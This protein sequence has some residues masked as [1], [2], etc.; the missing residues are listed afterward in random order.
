MIGEWM[1]AMVRASWQGAIAVALVWI[2]CKSVPRLP[3]NIRCWLW[4][5]ALLKTLLAALPLGPF[6]VPILPRGWVEHQATIAAAGA[7][8]SSPVA[9]TG[10]E[11]G[12]T[13]GWPAGFGPDNAGRPPATAATVL[14]PTTANRVKG[15][16]APIGYTLLF[17]AWLAVLVV[18]LGTLVVRIRGAR[19]W[20]PEWQL[21]KDRGVLALGERLSQNLGLFQP[22]VLFEADSCR[23]PVVFGAVR[24]AIVLPARLVAGSTPG[25]LE[26]ILAHEM[27]HIRRYDL[28]GNW[29]STLVSGLFFFHPLVWLAVRESRLSQEV[30]CDELTVRRPNVSVADYG[31]LLVELATQR[32]RPAIPLLTV[33]V[34]ESF[35]TFLKR[36]LSAMKSI[37]TRSRKTFVLS[38]AVAVVAVLG[39]LPWRLAAA[40]KADA[41]PAAGEPG[42]QRLNVETTSGRFKI[43]VDRVRYLPGHMISM[44]PTAL[45]MLSGKM[46]QHV[47]EQSFPGGMGRAVTGTMGGGGGGV[48][49]IPNLALDVVVK[50]P[51]LA[52]KHQLVCEIQ[53]KVHAVDDRGHD[54]DS[55]DNPSWLKLQL[56]GVDYPQGSGRVA[57]HLNLP[58]SDPEARYLKTVEGELLVADGA[59]NQITFQGNDLTRKTSKRVG[60]FSARLDKV[61][62]SSDGV[63]VTLAVSE[64]EKHEEINPMQNPMEAMQRMMM[65]NA[66]GRVS[67]V[68]LDSEGKSHTGAAIGKKSTG[69]NGVTVFGGGGNGGG[70][71]GSWRRVGPNG[72]SG[73]SFSSSKPK[74][75]EP[76]DYHF[77]ILPA[78]VTIKAITC[79][80]TDITGTPKTVPFKFKDIRLPENRQ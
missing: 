37:G 61:E 6:D 48:I 53:G 67:V 68:L 16:G 27:A 18:F 44:V 28:L 56:Q 10:S 43:A 64:P 66:S 79:T 29:F 46:E 77:D 63:D 45:P 12:V 54:V 42:E 75:S 24:T 76:Q 59:I 31:R 4:R 32:P 80:V 14:D 49:T 1:A 40:P 73:G 33:G 60:G 47:E 34:V 19:R 52:K 65:A 62:D 22:P 8:S 21:I 78:G 7:D 26:L 17:A 5:L 41:K 39:L 55:S 3:A 36:R 25:Q 38:W 71:S 9:N 35:Q 20:R 11:N 15:Q 51:K 57:I 69:P 30:A 50:G 58:P 70:S 74:A 13:G 23:S 72:V 2:V